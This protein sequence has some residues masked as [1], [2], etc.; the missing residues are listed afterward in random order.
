M[1]GMV[2]GGTKAMRPAEALWRTVDVIGHVA[3]ASVYYRH[4]A[5]HVAC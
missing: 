5:S 3:R 2:P 4:T 1:P